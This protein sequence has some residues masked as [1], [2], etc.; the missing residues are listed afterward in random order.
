MEICSNATTVL[1]NLDD[2]PSPYTDEMLLNLGNR[3]V[4]YESSRGC[5]YSCSYCLSSITKG[6]RYF[7]MD[8]V[9]KEIDRL[10]KTG[11]KQI[12][13][14][15]RTFNCNR[16]RALEIFRLIIDRYV[17]ETG[18]PLLNFHFEAAA[19]LFDEE[20]IAT[21]SRAPRGLIQFEIG[22]QT[23]NPDSLEAIN[24]KTDLDKL[25]HNFLRLKEKGNIH[26]H[27][28]LIAG[29]PYEDYNSF[30]QSFK[31]VYE[32][33]PH[34]LQLGFLKLL[35]GSELRRRS[36]DF[37]YVYREYPPYEVL[38]NNYI[39]FGELDELKGIEDLLDR[40]F[41]SGRF[42]SSLSYVTGRCFDSPFEFYRQLYF[43]YGRNGLLHTPQ[44]LREQ[45]AILYSFASERIGFENAAMLAEL[46]RFDFLASDGSGSLPQILRREAA[47]GFK[48][49]CFDFLREERNVARYLPQYVGI[50]AK[51]TIK[52]VQFEEFEFNVL[53]MEK[54][55]GK[56]VLL[57]DYS[58]K[59]SVSGLFKVVEVNM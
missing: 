9:G 43:Y 58:N 46:L 16:S 26:L 51:Q 33:G 39:S 19:D 4:Y 14:V 22:V 54:T 52:K 40:Y 8:R 2:I 36:K 23:V 47:P 57:F 27:L 17:D 30:A 37:G 38:F 6:V 21:L 29:L 18:A 56:T 20:M 24:R 44:A 49:K 11:V 41:N 59:D 1:A 28:D 15:D 3:I 55:D 5:P 12:K 31:R 48:E 50:P 42:V 25:F 13:F 53:T 45:Y 32:A 7:S 10:V 35:K 34:Q